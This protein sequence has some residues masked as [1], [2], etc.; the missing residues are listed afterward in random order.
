MEIK[1]E[2]YKFE[3]GTH[4]VFG[5]LA[6]DHRTT[7]SEDPLVVLRKGFVHDGLLRRQPCRDRTQTG[8]TSRGIPNSYSE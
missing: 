5:E 3:S 2:L 8:R 4:L 1:R 6:P 7:T